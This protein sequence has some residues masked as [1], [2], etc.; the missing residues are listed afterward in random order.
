M[1]RIEFYIVMR[2]NC[3]KCGS[4]VKQ[5]TATRLWELARQQKRWARKHLCC[6][7]GKRSKRPVAL[8]V[9]V[10]A[11]ASPPESESPA[12]EALGLPVA[13]A[14]VTDG[15]LIYYRLPNGKRRR[16]G[17]LVAIAPDKDG[18]IASFKILKLQR[19]AWIPANWRVDDPKKEKKETT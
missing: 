2:R 6:R 18:K 12:S 1:K 9:P 14:A 11:V 7:C 4:T 15:E 3:D 17:K 5:A 16:K 10:P 19:N 13:T 8:P